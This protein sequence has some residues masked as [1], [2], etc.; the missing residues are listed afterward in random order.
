[1]GGGA[2]GAGRP[3]LPRPSPGAAGAKLRV[4]RRILETPGGHDD[5]AVASR[6][7]AA[8][9]NEPA[10]DALGLAPLGPEL[11]RIAALKIRTDVAVLAAHLQDVATILPGPGQWMSTP[12]FGFGSGPDFNDATRRMAQIGTAGYALPDRDIYLKSDERTVALRDK[13]RDHVQQMLALLGEPPPAA[14]AS[15]RAVVA[16]ETA[17]AGATLDAVSPSRSAQ[18]ASRAD[19]GGAAGADAGLRLDRLSRRGVGAGVG[20]DRR[21]SAGLHEGRQHHRLGGADCGSAGVLPLAPGARL[22]ADA[23]GRPAT[24][25]LRLLRPHA[26][27]SAG[28][29]CASR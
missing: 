1:M 13:Y 20:G 9:V 29:V 24:V 16:I 28:A 27:G 8:C 18:R 6:Y 21:V 5:R 15:A 17:L 23:A 4:L 25:R 10:I 2:S 14:A 7:Y 12:L 22:G 11:T 19:A 3:A 26:S